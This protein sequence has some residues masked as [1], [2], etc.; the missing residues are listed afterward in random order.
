MFFDRSARG[1]VG[2]EGG[3][4]LAPQP[5][6]GLAL[7]AGAARGWAHIGVIRALIENGVEPRIVAGTSIGAVVGGCYAAG[8]LAELEAFARSL[9][10]RRVLGLMDVRLGRSGLMAGERLR[11][12][13]ERDLADVRVEDLASPF[14][15]V[16]TELRSGHEIWLT[17]GGL[18]DAMRASYALPG[19]FD[20]VNIAGRWLVDGALVN[21][22]PVTTA[23][24]LGADVILA[25][26]LHGD[27]LKRGAIIPAHG[28]I[29]EREAEGKLP[30][31]E[32]GVFGQMRS[33]ASMMNPFARRGIVAASPGM[34][35]VMIDAFNIVQ[36]RIARSRMAG[37]PP[38]ITVSP[39]LG[40]LGLFEFH[41]ADEAI[42]LGREATLRAMPEIMET[43]RPPATS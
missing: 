18:V 40:K 1:A 9:S 35:S 16:A 34:A 38:D 42:A 19:V 41:R 30:A 31:V 33:A 43:L 3:V 10:M 37:D 20:P 4:D 8:R 6:L 24:A 32:R 26:N 36:D 25:V 39:R 7:G 5:R 2:S 12:A 13:L 22:I 27:V 14:A 11:R 29:L 21:P 28:E 23:R 17:R 15:A